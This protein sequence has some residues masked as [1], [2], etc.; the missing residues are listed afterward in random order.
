MDYNK[1]ATLMRILI[2]MLNLYVIGL[3]E[4]KKLVND[5]WEILVKFGSFIF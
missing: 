3:I 2:T 4:Q 1:D 5:I